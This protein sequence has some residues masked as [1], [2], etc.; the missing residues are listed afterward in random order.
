MQKIFEIFRQPDA[1]SAAAEAG[2]QLN[3]L[4]IQNKTKPVLLMVSG[5]SAL[6]I[7]D[8]LGQN[9]LGANLTISMLD[10]RFT[11]DPK[12]NNFHQLQKMDFYQTALQAECS[13]FSTLPRPEDTINSLTTRWQTNL[14]NWRSENPKGIIIATLGMGPDGHTAGMFPYPADEFNKLFNSADWIRAY[15]VGDKNPFSDRITV[16]ITFFKMID[17]GL[18][19]V[20][21]AEKKQKLDAILQHQGKISDLPALAWQEIKKVKVFTDQEEK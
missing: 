2:E 5:G 1:A 15:N 9:A 10:E 20:S 18:A 21:G 13:F 11:E 12:I 3:Q 4:L 6:S 8:Y 19:Y 7:L 16:T 14:K 17:I